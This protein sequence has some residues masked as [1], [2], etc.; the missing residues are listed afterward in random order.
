M[1]K[2]ISYNCRNSYICIYFLSVAG[3]SLPSSDTCSRITDQFLLV[4]ADFNLAVKDIITMLTNCPCEI[5]TG[6]DISVCLFYSCSPCPSDNQCTATSGQ[7]FCSTVSLNISSTCLTTHGKKNCSLG[8]DKEYSC[9]TLTN[10]TPYPPTQPSTGCSIEQ[11]ADDFVFAI[12]WKVTGM[13]NCF[14]CMHMAIMLTF[15]L[16]RS[17]A[18]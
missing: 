8:S 17:I 13:W 10:F 11:N 12:Q 6:P 15:V 2:S 5:S 7:C 14:I 4:S 3:S 18:L 1:Y 16:K 9:K